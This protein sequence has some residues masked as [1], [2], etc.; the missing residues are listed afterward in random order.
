VHKLRTKLEHALPKTAFIHTHP[1]FGYR[2]DPFHK[3]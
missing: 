2:F 1:S 3:L